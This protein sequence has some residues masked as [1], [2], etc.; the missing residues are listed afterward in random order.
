H[1][2]ISFAFEDFAGVYPHDDDLLVIS[3]V[4]AGFQIKRAMVDT[5]SSA[6][7]LF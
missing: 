4:T 7:V 5:G 1:P 2:Q 3:V 6:N